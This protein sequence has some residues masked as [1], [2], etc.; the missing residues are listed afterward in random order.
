MTAGAAALVLV[1]GASAFDRKPITLSGLTPDSWA[2]STTTAE[3]DLK[4]RYPGIHDVYCVGVQIPDDGDSSFVSAGT[5][6]WDKLAC[7]G[8]TTG[9]TEFALVYDSKGRDSWIVYPLKGTSIAA[10]RSGGGPPP[11][12]ESDAPSLPK[13]ADFTGSSIRD[14]R[15]S[16]AAYALTKLIG[17]PHSI[18]VAC[19]SGRDWPGVSGDSADSAYA[20]LAFWSPDMPHWVELSPTVAARWRRCS[21]TGPP[22]R[23]CSPRTP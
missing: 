2:Q 22:T 12:S 14:T 6:Y 9:G 5:R 18:D 8:S 17:E 3:A 4:H 13:A 15:L 7:A 20:T 11:A 1:P 16:A 21:G 23:T 10:L 19:W